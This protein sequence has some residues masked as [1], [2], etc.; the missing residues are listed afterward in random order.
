MH[1]GE[2]KKRQTAKTMDTVHYTS[3]TG[4]DLDLNK[5]FNWCSVIINTT[6][7]IAVTNWR[8]WNGFT[9]LQCY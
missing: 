1:I 7:S 2:Q 4:G 3:L 8:R 5:L 6:F 9:I